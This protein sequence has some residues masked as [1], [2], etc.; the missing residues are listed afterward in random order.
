MNDLEPFIKL[1]TALEPWRNQIVFVGGWAYRLFRLHPLAVTPSYMSIFTRD[2]D[3]AFTEHE[4]LEGSIKDALVEAGFQEKLM[5]EYK[6]PVAQYTLGDEHSGFYAEFLTTLTGSG[7]TRF[8]EPAVTLA[9]AG[10]TAQKLRHLDLL[11]ACPWPVTIEKGFGGLAEDLSDLRIPNPVSFM[12]QKVLIHSLRKKEKRPQDILYIH[13]AVQ[14]FGDQLENLATLWRG[15]L[16]DTLI[17]K[18]RD[19]VTKGIET[20]FSTV[21]DAIRDAAR[22]PQDRRLV[23]EEMQMTCQLALKIVFG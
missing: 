14:L 4:R 21:T 9:K 10:V 23:P 7:R 2:A 22:I 1:A 5:S 16:S 12:A 15:Q 11:L 20:M 8:G 6:P 13:D 17:K 18:D 3:V 19:D